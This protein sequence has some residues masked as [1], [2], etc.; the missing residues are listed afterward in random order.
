MTLL[1][2]KS[3]F[4][5]SACVVFFAYCGYPVIVILLARFLGRPWA[6]AGSQ[7]RLSI[8]IAAYNESR[9]IG[10]KIE[11]TLRL[12]CPGSS[13]EVAVVSDGSSDGTDAIV[14]GF[15]DRGVRL[16]QTGRRVGKTEAQNIAVPQLSGEIVVFSDATTVLREDTLQVLTN[17]FS[18]PRVGGVEARLTYRAAGSGHLGGKDVAKGYEAAV[19]R[20]ESLLWGGVGDNGACYAIRKE[21]WRPLSP[22]LTSDLA[23]PLDVMRQ[24]FRFVFE[25]SAISEEEAAASWT[26]EFKRKIRTVRAGVHTVLSSRDLL[27]SPHHLWTAFVLWGRKISRWCSAFMLPLAFLT[28]GLLA[29]E[30]PYAVAFASLAAGLC[31]GLA[32]MALGRRADRSRILSLSRGFL[33][34]NVAA[35]V[36][37]VLAIARSNTEAWVPEREQG[38]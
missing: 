37:S 34:I 14:S 12:E 32:G 7:P 2:L 5:I 17:A 9:S 20:A 8:L 22:D 21:L 18:D 35:I 19:K 27:F 33:A 26:A 23:A 29:A 6:N 11:E 10:R 13:L 3:A 16:I 25:P 15:A 38:G 28:A 4:W 36:G 24:G 1:L 30:L 31:A